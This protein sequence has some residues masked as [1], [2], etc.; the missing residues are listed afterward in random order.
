MS[1][2]PVIVGLGLQTPVGLNLAANVAAVQANLNVFRLSDHLLGYKTGEH[3]KISQL[4]TLPREWTPLERMK[5]M[6]LAAAKEALGPL[7]KLAGS[8]Q[9]PQEISMLLSAPPERPGFPAGS[10]AVLFQYLMNS[11]PLSVRKEGSGVGA[12][13]HDGGL[14]AVHQAAGMIRAGIVDFCLVGGVECY[15]SPETLYWLES[16]ERLKL[17]TEPNGFIP[18]EGASFVL[19]CSQERAVRLGLTAPVQILSTGRGAEER[20][21]H[22]GLP[23]LGTGLSQAFHTLF[24]SEWTPPR[25]VR[26]TYC[27]LNGESWRADEWGYAYVRTG[28]RHA[29]P[30]H[31][32]HPAANWGDLGAASGPAL[33]A[34]ATVEFLQQF[35]PEDVVLVWT[36]SDMHPSRSACLLGRAER[37]QT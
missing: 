29:S 36:A 31:L 21:W 37:Q 32:R 18:G 13:G 33:L 17:E 5:A 16:Q 26:A 10:G 1:R 20:L 9:A 25:R 27:D 3:L 30:L 24:A 6:A 4:Q 22:T 35:D 34:L 14:A 28:E 2:S 11:L 23:N 19:L 15:H 8:D 12:L 7:L